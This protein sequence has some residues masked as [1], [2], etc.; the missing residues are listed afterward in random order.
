MDVSRTRAL[1]GPNLWSRHTAIEAVVTCAESELAMRQIDGFESRLR[2]L[3]PAVGVLH[4]EGSDA[5]VSLAHVL[6]GAALALQ[7]QAGCP[8]SFSRIS[9]TVD[10]GV[11]QVV[12]EYS[13]E[14][15]GRQAFED[16]QA[17]IQAALQ[18]GHFDAE[19]AVARL[20][21]LDED[22]RL[23]PSTGSIVEA[24]AARGIP[25]RRLTSGSLVQFGWGSK[26]RRIQAAEVDST[27]AVAESIAQDKDLTKRL[28]HAA[29]VPVPLG[30]PVESVDDAWK[31][32]QEVG[33][34]VVVKPQDGNQGKGVTV[35][36]TE[37]SQLDEAF[38]AAAEYGTVMV[39]RFLPGHDFRL[40]VVGDQL[41]AAARREPPQ[42]LGDGE[43]TVRE[44]VHLVNLDPRRGEGHAT[45]LTKIRLDDIAVARLAM[46]GLT[47]DAVP[48]K[49]QRVILRNNANLSTGGTATDVTDDVHP[50]VAARAIAAAQMVG[51]HI[52]GVDM[53]AEN[54]LQP[55]EVQGG[56]FVEV[57]AAPGLR[58]HLAPSYGK[59]RNVGQA[60][61]D[62]L[63]ANGQDGRI[64][65]VAVTGTNG[66]TTT[67]RLIAHLFSAQ[68]LRVGM[69][70]TDGVYVNGRQID[71]GDCSGPKSARNV[72]LHP[73][74]DA[75]VFETA[76]GGILREGLGFD[77]CQVAVVTNI[78]AG[79]HLGLNYIT[80]VDDLAVLKRVIVQNVAP[81]GYAV[82]N[83]A[84][85]IVAAMA[86]S[87]PGKVIYFAS[88]RHH[89]VMATHR[90]QGHRSV[91][92]DGESIVA[93][94]GSWRETIH[95]RDVP[96]TRNGKIGFQVENVMASVAAAWGAGLPWQTIRRGLSGFVNDSD[97]APGRF[98]VM[99]FKG[100]TVIADY[101]HNPDAMRALVAAVDALPGNRRS[102]VISGAGDRRDEDIRDQTVILGA[103]FDDVILYQD[104]AQRGRA[105][106]EV[107]ALLREGLAGASRTKHIEEIRGEFIAIDSALDR[108]Q[109]GDLCLVLVD[110]VEEALAHLA[111]RCAEVAA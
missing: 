59:P 51:L 109:P 64:P 88:D 40:L 29:G 71:S 16:A 53:V 58:M 98:N 35:N 97:N 15:V 31:A 8:V 46:Q 18:G 43:R 23:G 103:A 106:G 68:G 54:V 110:Q 100:A 56:G 26:Q 37:R 93:A 12:V 27:S 67:A 49:G 83:A 22:E 92:M 79:D 89:P 101:G 70:N 86:S 50:E 28:L 17:L 44:L 84:D 80:T 4:P 11:Y 9:A 78:G 2:A 63:F 33:L 47:P 65:V 34:P 19:A 105:D 48:A 13:E 14:A 108:L 90:A 1:R 99:D 66:K 5:D 77:R 72:L 24:A 55:L 57:N 36:I 7:A 20:R 111:K 73:E 25:W 39:E 42:V 104:A 87:T 96:I 6:G 21:E 85:P 69:T 60:M 81:D 75:A 62:K 95:L 30:R 52:C 45:S 41:V 91:Y 32:A 82:L 102:V 61:V 10:R 107:M 38:R 76:R 74:V 94:E 3:F